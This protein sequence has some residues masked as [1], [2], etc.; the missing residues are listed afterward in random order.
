MTRLLVIILIATVASTVLAEP[1]TVNPSFAP[2]K[3][4][5][6]QFD[7][8]A[9]NCKCI[10]YVPVDYN[11]DCNWPVLFFYHGKGA[12]LSAEQIKIATQ[13]KNFV[14]VCMEFAPTTAETMNPGQ[15][16]LYLQREIKNL[17]FVRH[18]LQTWLKIDPKM[19]VLSGFSR[20]GGLA[21]DILNFRPLIAAAM[22]D[23]GAGYQEWLMKDA[24]SLVGKYVY[25]GA[26]ETDENLL[27]AKKA[28]KYFANQGA[29]VTYEIYLGVGHKF[30]ADSP[31]L[32][33]WLSDLRKKLDSSAAKKPVNES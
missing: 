26:G 24:P 10:V 2:G 1:N 8:Q 21:A 16:R 4:A 9:I 23:I 33:N 12:P 6:L 14:I 7:T 3:E 30:K 19:T 22:V 29:E 25:I 11:D 5:L 17:A 28:I 32:Q 27:A 18:Y 13:G 20:G 31:K 15:Y